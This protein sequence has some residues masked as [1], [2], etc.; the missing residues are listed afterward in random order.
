MDARIRL[1]AGATAAA[2]L[3]LLVATAASAHTPIAGAER[4]YPQ[5]TTLQYKWGGSYPSWFTNAMGFAFGIDWTNSRYSNARLPKFSYSASG[6]GTVWYKSTT[7]FRE[8]DDV[9]WVGCANR[10]GQPNWEVFLRDFTQNPKPQSF[11]G[12]WVQTTGSCSNTCFDLRRVALH[13]IV[14][15]TMGVRLHDPQLERDTIMRDR[16]PWSP[17][18]GWDT[19]HIRRCDRAAAQLKY[20]LA[21]LAGGYA[22]CFDHIAGAGVAGLVSTLTASA[23][24][25]SACYGTALT[26]SGRLEIQ[27]NANY[28]TLAGNPLASRTVFIDRKLR[29]SSTWTLNF[30]TATASNANTGNNWSRS[31]TESGG[32]TSVT[33]DYRAR[34]RGETG[35][36][37]A[38]SGVVSL[39]WRHPCPLATG[40]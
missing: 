40:P 37:P 26:I 11:T 20:D 13:E 10:F 5:D 6:A 32:S 39:T 33:Y 27:Q 38:S 31:F 36:D 28:E 8:C 12:T 3:V 35:V 23:P 9:D 34:Y 14:H 19:H 25:T 2:A 1:L 18:F 30:A 29:S 16:V 22:D 24:V 17:N 4:R 15:V 21:A 7:G